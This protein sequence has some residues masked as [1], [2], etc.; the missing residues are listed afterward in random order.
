M[1]NDNH[2]NTQYI[3]LTAEFEDFDE[4]DVKRTYR[5]CNPGKAKIQRCQKEMIKSPDKAFRTLVLD[6][7]HT[8]EREAFL[9]DID[10]Y[11]GLPTT[12]GNEILRRTGFDSLGK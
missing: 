5:F 6:C 12:F 8:D 4:K 2:E 7:V 10:K 9:D 1:E 11:P 3:S